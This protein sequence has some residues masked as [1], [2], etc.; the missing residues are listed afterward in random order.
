MIHWGTDKILDWGWQYFWNP[1]PRVASEVFQRC[2][3]CPNHNPGKLVHTSV[4][5]F[6]LPKG[7]FKL[8]QLDFIQL[9]PSQGCNSFGNGLYVFSLGGSFSCQRA[10]ALAM[11]K[12]LLEKIIPTWRI[13]LELPSDRGTHFTGQILSAVCDTWPILQHFS[14]AYHP[15][16]W[17][18]WEDKWYY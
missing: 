13:P 7:P 5:H 16:F 17:V 4:G 12:I 18:G 10:S 14:C 11:A 8:W 6:P 1:S 3:V 9:P 2:L 15:L